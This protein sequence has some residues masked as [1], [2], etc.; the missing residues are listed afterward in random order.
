[1]TLGLQQSLTVYTENPTT[2]VYDVVA[3]TNVAAQFFHVGRSPAGIGLERSELGAIR[4]LHYEPGV[5]LPPGCQLE[6]TE[7]GETR[8]YHVVT[9]T[10]GTIAPFGVV[11]QRRVDVTRAD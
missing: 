4:N 3:T 7:Y 11:I 9:G 10:D 8:R 1:M 6:V 2:G 5:T